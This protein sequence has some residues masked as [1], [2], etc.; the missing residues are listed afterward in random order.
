MSCNTGS[1]Q[2]TRTLTVSSQ[3]GFN[4]TSNETQ[5]QTASCYFQPCPVDC[6]WYWSQYSPC[7]QSCGV[8][9]STRTVVVTQVSSNGGAICPITHIQSIPCTV[10]LCSDC[11]IS[12]NGPSRV[13]CVHGVCVDGVPFDSNFTCQCSPG[14]TGSNCQLGWF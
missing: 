12:T 3:A 1:Q 8:G 13:G 6:V 2:Q 7:S 10:S 9:L 11:S 5:A 14:Y 4:C